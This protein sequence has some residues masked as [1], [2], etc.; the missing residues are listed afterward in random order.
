MKSYQY[1]LAYLD[2]RFFEIEAGLKK[3]GIKKD[4]KLSTELILMTMTSEIK[5]KDQIWE[6]NYWLVKRQRDDQ[7]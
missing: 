7:N 3:A 6:F 1:A 5:T 2:K 4:S